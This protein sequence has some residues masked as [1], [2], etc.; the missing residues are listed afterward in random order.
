MPPGVQLVAYLCVGY[1]TE[2][3]PQ[4]LLQAVGWKDRRPLDDLV[5][6]DRW[7]ERY[8]L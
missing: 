1:P 7:G 8:T 3:H 6:H 4:P 5:Y 2:F